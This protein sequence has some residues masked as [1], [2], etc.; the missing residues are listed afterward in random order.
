MDE[1]ALPEVEEPTGLATLEADDA[2]E[3]LVDVD[4]LVVDVLLVVVARRTIFP[5]RSAPHR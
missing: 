3:L 4:L 2:L 5:I 1:E